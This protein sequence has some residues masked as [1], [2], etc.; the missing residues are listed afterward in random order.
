MGW[1]QCRASILLIATRTAAQS[2]YV[3]IMRLA[4]AAR[5]SRPWLTDMHYSLSH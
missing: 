5:R 3:G 1:F 4:E 2:A